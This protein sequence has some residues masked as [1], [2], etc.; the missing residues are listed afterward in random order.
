[1]KLFSAFLGCFLLN[2]IVSHAFFNFYSY[3]FPSLSKIYSNTNNNLDGL[4]KIALVGAGPGDPDL[5]TIQ[6]MNLL[7]NASLVVA[8]RLVSKEIINLIKCEVRIAEKQPGCAEEA[9]EQIYDWVKDGVK[10]GLNVVRL[11]IGDPFVFG[12]A[13]EEIL[14]FR[15]LG[16]EPIIATG[17]S[18]SY[19]APLAANIPLTH[20][21]VSNQVVIATG[22]GKG[23]SHVELPEY[24]DDRTVV[25]LM[26]VGRISKIALEMIEMGYPDTTPVAIIEKATTPQQRTIRGNLMTI[27]EKARAA[28]AKPPSTIIVGKCVDTLY[29]G[30]AS[31]NCDGSDSSDNVNIEELHDGSYKLPSMPSI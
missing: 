12:R 2:L 11:K 19:S 31:D 29:Q 5:L 4:G 20:R 18:S 9:Q 25:L 21:G 23:G 3:K 30:N 16:I 17:I 7:N 14:E 10:K 22:Y 13:G 27:G 24:R 28:H 8:D 1:M 15:K 6:A 26:A